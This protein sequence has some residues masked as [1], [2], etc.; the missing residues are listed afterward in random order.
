M[1]ISYTANP[2]PST[3]GF[4]A[5]GTENFARAYFDNLR[6]NGTEIDNSDSVMFE[7]NHNAIQNTARRGYKHESKEMEVMENKL[8]KLLK[9]NYQHE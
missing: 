8:L 5:L 3:N 2:V 4:V 1:L 7:L 6:I 9:T